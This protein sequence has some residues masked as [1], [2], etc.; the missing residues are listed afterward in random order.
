MGCFSSKSSRPL[1]SKLLVV[2]EISIT[3][4][5]KSK[6]YAGIHEDF[7]FIKILG[8]G[9]YGTVRE[10]IKSSQP[11][12][13][14]AIKSIAK[15]KI[16]KHR[17]LLKRELQILSVVDH[18]NIIRLYETYEDELYLHLVMELCTGGDV[19]ER[20]ITKGFFSE[21]EASNIMRKILA[22][23][24]YLHSKNIIHR[25]LK[26]DNFLYE[27]QNSDEIK[28]CDFGM[29]IIADGVTR[30]NSM[31]G[32]PFY[33]APEVFKGS[34]TKSCDIWSLGVF[35]YFILIGKQPFKGENLQSI[36]EKSS[37][38]FAVLNTSRLNLLS[39]DAKDLLKKMLNVIPS[40]RINLDN[41]LVHPWITQSNHKQE[42]IPQSVFLSLC[43]YKAKSKLWQEAMKIVIN[44][45]STTEIK[46]LRDAFIA[47]DVSRSGF[48]TAEELKI[49]MK[50]H[51]FNLAS[52]E[53]DIII[54][55]CSYIESG[56]INYSDFL[57]ATLGKK[58]IMDQENLWNA[59]KMFQIEKN[60]KIS[61][62]NLNLVLKKAGCEFTEEEFKELVSGAQIDEN[63]DIDFDNFKVIM[64]CFDEEIK[65]LSL[66]ARRMS[67]ERLSTNDIKK[68]IMKSMTF[69]KRPPIDL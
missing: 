55:N 37:K 3:A 57:V 30:L 15:K 7:E 12:R 2:P 10:A 47:I 26:A 43:K 39:D 14:F 1:K 41:A 27:S 50:T 48:I 31:A 58:I 45:L 34:Y 59:F 19:W 35:M 64:E 22:A 17:L 44:N 28:I 4:N 63:F 29:S 61:L 46:S 16:S 36:Y 6:F 5:L 66:N 60:G 32:T 67:L 25:D 51:G 62:K 49:A 69:E 38:G 8:H 24:N 68:K 54:E 23:V 18:P 65:I 20:L 53:I 42:K 11:S 40:K 21:I 13:H 56:K 52:N 33:L 9:Q